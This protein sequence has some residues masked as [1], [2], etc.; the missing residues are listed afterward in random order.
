MSERNE[1]KEIKFL[2]FRINSN[3]IC[4]NYWNTVEILSSISIMHLVR[5]HNGV[6]LFIIMCFK[7]L[8]FKDSPVTRALEEWG[9]GGEAKLRRL[10]DGSFDLLTSAKRGGAS[11]GYGTSLN[12]LSDGARLGLLDAWL[13]FLP[14]WIPGGSNT[15]S[16][17]IILLVPFDCFWKNTRHGDCF[18]NISKSVAN[19]CA[20][21]PDFL[22]PL[23]GRLCTEH[24]V[25]SSR[26]HQWHARC[27]FAI[28]RAGRTR[29]LPGFTSFHW[30]PLMH[31]CDC[32]CVSSDKHLDCCG[33]FS[34]HLLGFATR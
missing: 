8:V 34:F 11:S 33:W 18:L 6:N 17:V 16:F 15:E 21:I 19:V 24:V 5:V 14:S 31:F 29:S 26:V 23:Q 27:L 30:K 4:L 10:P 28:H 22:L 1:W 9:E 7:S 12:S 3:K 13:A 32:F 2:W 20:T 25:C